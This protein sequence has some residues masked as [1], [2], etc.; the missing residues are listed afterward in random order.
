VL[1]D[2]VSGTG[3]HEAALYWHFDPR[4]QLACETEQ[5]LRATHD[6]GEAAWLVHDAAALWLVKGDDESQLGFVSPAYGARVPA[7]TARLSHRQ[8]APFAMVTWI[9]PA[10]GHRLPHLQRLPIECDLPAVVVGARIAQGIEEWVTVVR[11][12]A[13]A[14]GAYST[15]A[16]HTDARTLQYA[17]T[18]GRLTS[19]NATDISH[20]LPLG[21]GL[22]ALSVEGTMADLSLTRQADRLELW[23]TVPAGVRLQGRIVAGAKVISLNGR[24]LRRPAGDIRETIEI[25][26][27]DW[28]AS[29][30]EGEPG[31]APA[32][33]PEDERSTENLE[34]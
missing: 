27:T 13:A 5:C 16:Y 34:A 19:L 8:Q 15:D 17:I 32:R 9:G 10:R 28:G 26:S 20:A 22:L 11:P 21:D 30:P 33:E 4:W 29:T 14:A 25:A 12:G 31:V 3:E 18:G 6:T 7:W 2:V 1:V 24:E 23:S